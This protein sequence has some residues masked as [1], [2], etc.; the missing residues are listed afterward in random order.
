VYY[1]GEDGLVFASRDG[2]K[3]RVSER[4]SKI[5]LEGDAPL[6]CVGNKIYELDVNG[7]TRGRLLVDA[8]TVTGS[9][10]AAL[11]G[12]YLLRVSGGAAGSF[13]RSGQASTGLN[14]VEAGRRGWTTALPTSAGPH[15]FGAPYKNGYLQVTSAIARLIA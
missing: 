10:C 1:D 4:G 7:V 13:S 14:F 5:V 2:E 12:G 8:S 9:P 3:K 6:C 11:F 15:V